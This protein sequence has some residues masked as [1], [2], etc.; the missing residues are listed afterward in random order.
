MSKK[1]KKPE[2]FS[3]IEKLFN[4]NFLRKLP[5]WQQEMVRFYAQRFGSYTKFPGQI[6]E[7]QNPCVEVPLHPGELLEI[8]V[9]AVDERA[10]LSDPWRQRPKPL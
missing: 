3:E 6:A 4:P 8:I 10:P 2:N 1:K 5:D 9:G 7:C